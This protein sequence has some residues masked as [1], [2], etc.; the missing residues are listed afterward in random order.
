MGSIADNDSGGSYGYRMSK[1]ALNAAGKSLS[2]DL[3]EEGHPVFLLHPG[4]VKTDMTNHTGYID[5]NESAEGLYQ[6]MKNKTLADTGTFWH[7]NG[8][9]LPW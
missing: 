4:Y 2:V 6:V 7:T 3:K 8:E 1:A 5:T 9:P